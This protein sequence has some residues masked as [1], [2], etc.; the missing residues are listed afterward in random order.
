VALDGAWRTPP[1]HPKR[2][3][4]RKERHTHLELRKQ[5]EEEEQDE[6]EQQ[7]YEAMKSDT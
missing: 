3:S 5:G 6:E 4:E 1:R 2:A 7:E